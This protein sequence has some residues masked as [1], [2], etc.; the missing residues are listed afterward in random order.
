M[1]KLL[2]PLLAALVLANSV[3]ASINPTDIKEQIAQN[4]FEK[5]LSQIDNSIISEE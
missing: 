4:K 3:K 5:A 1:R 2:I